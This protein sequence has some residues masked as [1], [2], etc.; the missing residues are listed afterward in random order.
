MAQPVI[1]MINGPNLNKLGTREPALYG[2]QTLQDIQSLCE[3]EASDL[4]LRLV[5]A[6]SNHEGALV[7]YVQ[8]ASEKAQG[9]ILNAAA[10]THTSVALLDAAKL[11]RV[12][13]IEVHLSNIFAREA[14][15]H[16]SFISPIAQG[17]ICGF[18]ADSYLLALRALAKRLHN[19]S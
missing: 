17:V 15:R 11:L 5:F 9:V 6:Q 2:S 7:D 12:P 18:G 4:G 1:Y 19:H 3:K 16:H 13:L 8:E 10:Y 14:F